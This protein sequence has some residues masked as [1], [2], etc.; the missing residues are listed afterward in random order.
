MHIKIKGKKICQQKLWR[1][2]NT[3]RTFFDRCEPAISSKDVAQLRRTSCYENS[4]CI[5]E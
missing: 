1:E 3:C 4:R 5:N 2:R